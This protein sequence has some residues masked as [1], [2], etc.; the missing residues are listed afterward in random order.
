MT[1]QYDENTQAKFEK[2]YN[3]PAESSYQLDT[4]YFSFVAGWDTLFKQERKDHLQPLQALY[5]NE[6]GELISFHVNCYAGGFPNLKWNRNGVMESFPPG[7]QAPLDTLL[8]LQKQLEF[9]N[10]TSRSQKEIKTTDYTVVVYWSAYM[11][12]QSKRLIKQ[13]Q[14]NSNLLKGDHLQILYVN[15]DQAI[16]EK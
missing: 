10:P 8:S 6:K 1:L 5:Y 4:S 15:S 12:R 3:I 16:L 2:K 11:G 9:L 7:Q 14:K 13:V